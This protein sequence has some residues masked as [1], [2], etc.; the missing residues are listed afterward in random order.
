ME[1]WKNLPEIDVVHVDNGPVA[2]KLH[3][4]WLVFPA[5]QSFYDDLI[6]SVFLLKLYFIC[7]GNIRIKLNLLG[8]TKR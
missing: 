7:I 8:R 1:G 3:D 2:V 5:S 4:M 6:H